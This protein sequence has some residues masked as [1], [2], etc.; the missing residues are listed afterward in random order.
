MCWLKKYIKIICYIFFNCYCLLKE[1]RTNV[2][3]YIQT[4]QSILFINF[5]KRK[6][7][8]SHVLYMWMI[9]IWNYFNRLF[10]CDF[11]LSYKPHNFSDMIEI[12]R[13]CRFSLFSC[14]YVCKCEIQLP[15]LNIVSEICREEELIRT[16]PSEIR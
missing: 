7:E 14:E 10:N 8:P 4:F 15:S 1:A 3:F 5:F 11:S 9:F 2:S 13:F 12:G 6:W 16:Q